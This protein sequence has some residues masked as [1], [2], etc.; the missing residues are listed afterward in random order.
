MADLVGHVLQ[1]V[2]RRVVFQVSEWVDSR[3]YVFHLYITRELA[4]EWQTFSY[5]GI[6]RAIRRDEL[7]AILNQP[8]LK[9]PR[10]LAPAESGF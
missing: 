9:D 3:R 8:G 5:S 1:S 10:W 6:D 2:S 4:K 7:A